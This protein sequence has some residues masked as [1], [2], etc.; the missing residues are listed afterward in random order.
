MEQI[1][2]AKHLY[3]EAKAASACQIDRYYLSICAEDE[4]EDQVARQSTPGTQNLLSATASSLSGLAAATVRRSS[5]QNSAVVPNSSSDSINEG[6]AVPAVYCQSASPLRAK[7]IPLVT[8]S[9][10]SEENDNKNTKSSLKSYP[11]SPRS[12]RYAE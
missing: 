7:Q 8:S 4:E 6:P 11:S 1:F 3:E 12:E 2:K 5:F 9:P 10:S